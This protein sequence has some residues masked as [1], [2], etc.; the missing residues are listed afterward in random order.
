MQVETLLVLGN[1]AARHLVR[2]ARLPDRLRIVV[3]ETEEGL[4][5]AAGDAQVVLCGGTHRDLLRAIWPHLTRLQW[6]HA[7]AAGLDGLLFE[8]LVESPA[9]LTNSRAVFAPSLG[10][11]AMAAM[12][13]FAKDLR[14]ML[15]QQEAA[16]WD[17]FDVEMLEG[18]TLGIVGYGSIGREAAQRARA[19]GMKV[20]ALRQSAQPDEIAH[21][22][23]GPGELDFVLTKADYLLVAAPLTPRTR[24]MIGAEQLARLQPNA[25]VINLGRGPVLDE[26]ALAAAL[27]HRRI[28]GAALDVFETEPLPEASP[29]WKLDN[30]LLS[31]HCADHTPGWMESAMDLFV[32]NFTRFQQGQPLINVAD[33]REGY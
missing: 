32:E 24:G 27:A 30:V 18:A 26:A 1:P 6:V 7:L 5:R 31:P 12:L 15:R 33:K 20:I 29:L 28:R 19:F 8:E 22:V 14:R 17:P 2:L 10:E 25:V 23:V 21:T 9:P 3:A 4:L 16:V 11:F 13:W